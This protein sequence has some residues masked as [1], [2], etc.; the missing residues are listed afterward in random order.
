MKTL[1]S[2]QTALNV[3]WIKRELDKNQATSMP[4]EKW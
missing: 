2:S 3:S 1:R 4:G